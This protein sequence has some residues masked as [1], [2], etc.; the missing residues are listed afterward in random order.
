MHTLKYLSYWK[1][2]E[3]IQRRRK[4]GVKKIIR[5]LTSDFKEVLLSPELSVYN[6]GI[7]Q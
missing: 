3:G 6:C 7:L 1:K 4:K 2:G 5:F